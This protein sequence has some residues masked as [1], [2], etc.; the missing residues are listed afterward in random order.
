MKGKK[1]WKFQRLKVTIA[2]RSV[3]VDQLGFKLKESL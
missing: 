3:L 2:R 1:E